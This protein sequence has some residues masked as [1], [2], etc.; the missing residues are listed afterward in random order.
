MSVDELQDGCISIQLLDAKVHV[1]GDT[2]RGRITVD[3]RLPNAADSIQISLG[4]CVKTT[5]C[6]IKKFEPFHATDV[7]LKKTWTLTQ[8]NA[9]MSQETDGTIIWD[10]NLEIPLEPIR[11]GSTTREL[12][13]KPPS[14]LSNEHTDCITTS[15]WFP[16]FSERYKSSNAQHEAVVEYWLE[17]WTT[18][19]KAVQ[20]IF[21]H[22][23][24]TKHPLEAF[25][26]TTR[27]FPIEVKHSR[28]LPKVNTSRLSLNQ[29]II[30]R[31]DSAKPRR[32]PIQ[33]NLNVPQ[34]YQLDHPDPMPISLW[35]TPSKEDDI[36][37]FSNGAASSPS[38]AEISQVRVVLKS[39]C[40][41]CVPRDNTKSETLWS[42]RHLIK[43]HHFTEA[44]LIPTTVDTAS[45][46]IESVK[47]AELSSN[48]G[49]IPPPNTAMALG[50][51]LQ[52][53]THSRSSSCS[54][55]LSFSDAMN[56]YPSFTTCNLSL[57]YNLEID[58]RI[59]CG[60]ETNRVF[61]TG[62][63]QLLPESE[64]QPHTR[65]HH[66]SGQE[67]NNQNLQRKGRRRRRRTPAEILSGVLE[68]GSDA[69]GSILS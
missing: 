15:R 60:N 5:I 52:I 10:V 68:L 38:T 17:A 2:I 3:Q 36:I 27:T 64:A 16:T 26:S 30:E 69:F 9:V 56:L 61:Y 59:K 35:I 43:T 51:I 54:S 14:F 37:T 44:T 24:P 34:T 57:T 66:F 47:N 22:P 29:K 6:E 21:I 18:G 33:I 41:I 40:R 31:F 12:P 55:R 42:T 25:V 58:L 49:P 46:S 48:A 65:N 39:Q 20:P 67:L 13:K 50:Q 8:D 62:S 32:R 7:F 11:P 4:G 1:P 23:H 63:L 28:L 19:R 53:Y 45:D